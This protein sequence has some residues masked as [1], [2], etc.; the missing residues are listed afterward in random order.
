MSSVKL[1][2]FIQ[3]SNCWY[4]KL[5]RT[6]SKTLTSTV[7]LQGKKIRSMYFNNIAFL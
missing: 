4:G 5:Q 2:A 1:L 6:D 7:L 3:E